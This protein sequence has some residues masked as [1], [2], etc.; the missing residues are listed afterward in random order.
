MNYYEHHIGDYDKNTAH[1][2]ACQ[3]GIYSRMI[4]RYYDKEAPLPVDVVEIKRLVRAR[5]R[6]EKN[7]VD[8][9]LK[10][11]FFLREDGWHHSKC[12]EVIAAYQAGA[13]EREAKKR[14][15][16]TRVVRHRQERAELFKTINGAGIHL[17]YNTPMGELRAAVERISGAAPATPPVTP[18]ATA[19]VTPAT[20]THTPSTSHHP[21]VT[22]SSEHPAAAGLPGPTPA[23]PPEKP[24]RAR[25]PADPAPTTA[26]WEAYATAFKNRYKVEPMRNATVNGQLANL[27]ARVGAEE[28]PLI[29]AFYLRLD[30]YAG[31]SH[32]IGLLV[33][34]Y[35]GLRTRW[36]T[37][38][39]ASDT[40][41]V[42]ERQR[43]AAEI[44][45][46]FQREPADDRT[47]DMEDGHAIA[48]ANR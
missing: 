44:M 11:F 12:D 46:P 9:N 23:P 20:A 7:A 41:P 48:H 25:K 38:R 14:N 29:A 35:E 8:T 19:P 34:D 4:R 1:L 30:T 21:P 6:E 33:R 16:D 28:A 32:P 24:K 15:E 13:P 36:K 45:A 10:E 27:V 2:T 22:I 5:A 31:K 18:P 42:T 3:D 37:G 39:R 43:R 17:P 40:A 26:T 47:I